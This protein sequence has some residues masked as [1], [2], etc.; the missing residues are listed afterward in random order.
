MLRFVLLCLG[1]WVCSIAKSQ[2]IQGVANYKILP[3]ENSG[4]QEALTSVGM[5][6]SPH[7]KEIL[8]KFKFELHFHEN[9]SGF[10][11][12]KNRIRASESD[13][14]MAKMIIGFSNYKWQNA[15]RSLNVTQLGWGKN[16]QDVLIYVDKSSLNWIITEET[17]EIGGY[18]CFKATL[19]EVMERSTKN[20]IRPV[21]AWFTPE[22]PLPFGPLH[23]G[24]LPGLILELQTENALYGV[25]KLD[26]KKKAE[27][28]P[29]PDYPQYTE[30]ELIEKITSK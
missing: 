23:Y 12:T 9:Q 26:F 27:I 2:N 22:I 13:I 30:K 20:F 3:I 15:D 11:L 14:S 16:A 17:K 28:L 7:I 21:I 10:D 19:N 18:T 24:N 8:D 1:I 25:E 5:A 6:P 29:M 4:N